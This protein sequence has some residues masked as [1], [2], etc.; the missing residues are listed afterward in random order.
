MIFLIMVNLISI[1]FSIKQRFTISI[2]L[3][4]EDKR[5]NNEMIIQQEK[6]KPYLKLYLFSIEFN[7]AYLEINTNSGNERGIILILGKSKEHTCL[8]NTRVTD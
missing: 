2:R 4:K 1:L 6:Y 7:S 5:Y 8:A 3:N